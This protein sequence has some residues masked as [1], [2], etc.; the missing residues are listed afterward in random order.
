M[1]SR[2]PRRG[3]TLCP[4]HTVHE[5]LGEEWNQNCTGQF[6]NPMWQDASDRSHLCEHI[7]RS[8]GART[9]RARRHTRRARRASISSR[10]TIHCSRSMIQ[11]K[12]SNLANFGDCMRITIHLTLQRVDV[13]SSLIAGERRSCTTREH[14]TRKVSP[15][16]MESD[17][18][19]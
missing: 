15:R 9:E 12:T 17:C 14:G 4:L 6:E 13:Y 16:P 5:L 7:E 10:A 1:G 19:R 3:S 18:S 2:G 8:L 11:S